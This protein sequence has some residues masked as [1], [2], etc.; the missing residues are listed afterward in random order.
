MR[1]FKYI[2]FLFLIYLF[3][4]TS[5]SEAIH[6]DKVLVLKSTDFKDWASLIHV[7]EVTPLGEN[8][9]S[10]LSIAQKCLIGNE[11]I[12]FWDFKMRCVYTYNTKG[13]YLFTLGRQGGAEFECADLRDIYLDDN[14][15]E[16][17]DAT[18]ILVFDAQDGH[19]I[20]KEKLGMSNMAEY[21]KFMPLTDRKYL[22]FS[23]S[24]EFTIYAWE[25]GKMKGLQKNDGHQ[26]ITNHFYKYDNEC[27]VYPNY[28]H[29][30]IYSYVNDTFKPKYYFD[31]GDKAL[32]KDRLPQ[33]GHQFDQVDNQPEYFKS[34][35]DIKES[36]KWLYAKVV[37]PSQ[38]YY[39]IYYDKVSDRLWAGPSDLSLGLSVIDVNNEYFYGLVYP[40]YVSEKTDLYNTIKTYLPDGQESNP[41]LIK[42]RFNEN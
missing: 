17:L 35:T 19:F 37:G 31:F 25:N 6:A 10:L 38:T 40:E 9:D 33:T 7:E 11:R 24:A 32:P 1:F 42:F 16:L 22:F 28:G 39:D 20:K 29:F 14:K 36:D 23:P 2:P 18:G 34:V 4:C 21:F 8:E 15:I 27:L 41:I 30:V 26:L 12:L 5:N 3:S 13:E